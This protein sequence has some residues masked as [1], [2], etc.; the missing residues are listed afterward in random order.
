MT[1]LIEAVKEAFPPSHPLTF[2]QQLDSV[3]IVRVGNDDLLYAQSQLLDRI[4]GGW[5]VEATDREATIDTGETVIHLIAV[6]TRN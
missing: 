2:D 3:L 5:L 4:P 1:E 6:G